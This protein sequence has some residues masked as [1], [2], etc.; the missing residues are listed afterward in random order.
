MV[1][2]LQ[3]HIFFTVSASSAGILLRT[4]RTALPVQFVADPAAL[5]GDAHISYCPA[6]LFSHSLPLTAS[7][8]LLH[9]SLCTDKIS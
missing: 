2:E 7:S 8:A 3:M 1:A 4:Q 6:F 9:T 5:E